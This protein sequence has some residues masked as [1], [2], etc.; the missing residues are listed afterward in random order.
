MSP[1]RKSKENRNGK[2]SVKRVALITGA[3]AGIGLACARRL[4]KDGCS[5]VLV[6]RRLEA[7]KK[8]KSSLEK[9]YPGISVKVF[10][11]NLADSADVKVWQKEHRVLL[12]SV[13]I[14]INNAGLAKGTDKIQDLQWS[15]AEA[16][17]EVNMKGLLR[18]ALPVIKTM[19]E[20]KS[21][22]VVN[23]GSVAGRWVY[24]GGSVYCATKFAVR[25]LGEAMRQDLLGR[26]VRVTNIEPGM[27]NTEFSTVR[28][29]N[30][31]LADKVYEKMTPLSGDDIAESIS[32]CV[33]LPPHVNVQELVIYPTD[34]AHVGVGM[35]H[36]NI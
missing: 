5:L 21:G 20:K 18:F 27:V 10:K 26:N 33:N 1:N 3:S 2:K 8:L 11:L 14:L 34:Q 22:H 30:K 6:A 24:P 13:D 23:L 17:I 19:A 35:V 25:A 12:E 4:A 32:W 36:R 15:D 9:A 16:M 7:L 29:G 31:D 28:L